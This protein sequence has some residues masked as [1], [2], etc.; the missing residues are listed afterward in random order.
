M[1]NKIFY[2]IMVIFLL[3]LGASE[4]FADL[5]TE[6]SITGCTVMTPN[7]SC[8]ANYNIYNLSGDVV[9]TGAMTNMASGIYNFTISLGEGSYSVLLCTGHSTDIEIISTTEQIDNLTNIGNAVWDVNL[10]ARYPEADSD[11]FFSS[12]AGQIQFQVMRWIEG[13]IFFR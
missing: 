11:S 5:C 4:L 12:L 10:T 13:W 7:I 9:Q 8:S 2:T 6:R 1:K 3:A